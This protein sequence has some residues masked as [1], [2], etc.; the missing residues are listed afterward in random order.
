MELFY[1]ISLSFLH[2]GDQFNWVGS[3]DYENNFTES[4]HIILQA[5]TLWC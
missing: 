2:D 1:V 4:L 5:S 3:I